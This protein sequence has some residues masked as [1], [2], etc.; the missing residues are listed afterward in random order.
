MHLKYCSTVAYIISSRILNLHLTN[1][2]YG[3]MKSFR[4]PHGTGIVGNM[5][6]FLYYYYYYY[7][8]GNYEMHCF[9]A[10]FFFSYHEVYTSVNSCNKQ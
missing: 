5:K 9:H 8:I 1:I 6:L 3:K 10:V 2:F 7:Y 4:N